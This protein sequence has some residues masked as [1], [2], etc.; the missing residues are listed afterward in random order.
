MDF[1]CIYVM[2]VSIKSIVFLHLKFSFHCCRVVAGFTKAQQV[3]GDKLEIFR[4]LSRWFGSS[5]VLLRDR[6][7][8]LQLITAY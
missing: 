7:C 1:C 5:G 6:L 8:S 3:I 4:Y 2:L